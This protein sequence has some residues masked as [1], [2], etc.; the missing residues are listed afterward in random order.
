MCKVGWERERARERESESVKE[1]ERK[2]E[3]ERKESKGDSE[4]KREGKKK[5]PK[6]T[7]NESKMFLHFLFCVAFFSSKSL[8]GNASHS[9]SILSLPLS[10]LIH[11]L[12]RPKINFKRR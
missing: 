6:E 10:L 4:R 7:G 2:R 11:F 9:T 1:E 12:S 8:Y 5:G 3:E